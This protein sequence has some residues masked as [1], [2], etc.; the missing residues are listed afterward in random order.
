MIDSSKLEDTYEYEEMN[1][2][3]K[4]NRSQRESLKVLMKKLAKSW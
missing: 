4:W 3:E 1:L 2:N